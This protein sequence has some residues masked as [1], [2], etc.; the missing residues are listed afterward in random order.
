[1]VTVEQVAAVLTKDVAPGCGGYGSEFSFEQHEDGVVVDLKAEWAP[2]YVEVKVLV[3]G[4]GEE[5]GEQT[6]QYR[7]STRNGFSSTVETETVESLC[8]LLRDQASGC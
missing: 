3:V 4:L 1:V 6:V 2:R 7:D 5:D 8:D